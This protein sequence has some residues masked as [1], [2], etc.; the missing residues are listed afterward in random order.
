MTKPVVTLAE[1]N[2]P[3]L[4][5]RACRK[6]GLTMKRWVELLVRELGATETKTIK[7][8]GKVQPHQLS[9]TS[10][11]RIV[12][13]NSEE[14]IIQWDEVNW[15]IRQRARIEAQKMLGHYMPSQHQFPDKNGIPQAIGLTSLEAATKLLYLLTEAK[16]RKDGNGDSGT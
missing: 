14:T 4:V 10:G 11:S 8:R 1:M 12:G 3:D 15:P 7:V 13:G 2:G 6:H 9:S 5:E 16:A